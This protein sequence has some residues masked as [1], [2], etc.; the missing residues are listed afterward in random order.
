MPSRGNDCKVQPG[1]R[2][3]RLVVLQFAGYDDYRNRVWLCQCDC[4]KHIQVRAT[5]LPSGARTSCGC[6]RRKKRKIID[7][8]RLNNFLNGDGDL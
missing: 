5:E 4:G 3:G 8:S 7:T 6:R 2:F 1:D